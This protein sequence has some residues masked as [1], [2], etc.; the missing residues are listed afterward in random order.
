M[1]QLNNNVQTD[2]QIENQDYES[3]RQFSG[4]L[5]KEYSKKISLSHR[6][7]EVLKFIRPRKKF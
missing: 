2:L 7:Y 3:G 1:K 6:D 4:I 5:K